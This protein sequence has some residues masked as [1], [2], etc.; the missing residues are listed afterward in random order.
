MHEEIQAALEALE[1]VRAHR[2]PHFRRCDLAA[3]RIAVEALLDLPYQAVDLALDRMH[4]RLDR[5]VAEDAQTRPLMRK[6]TKRTY[7]R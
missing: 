4:R 7:R 2:G 6:K 5:F 3:S 1:R